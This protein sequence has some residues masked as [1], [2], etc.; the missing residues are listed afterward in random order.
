[1]KMSG[2]KRW[3]WYFRDPKFKIFWGSMQCPPVPPRLDH[4][5]H[6]NFYSHRGKKEEKEKKSVLRKTF[7]L[8][9]EH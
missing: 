1:M 4:L 3:K 7:K 9:P 6:Y 8:T 2:G 5:G